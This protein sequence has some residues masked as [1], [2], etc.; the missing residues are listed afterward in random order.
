MNNL[1]GVLHGVQWLKF[2][3]LPE[4][5]SSRLRDGSNTRQ[6]DHGAA[7]SHNS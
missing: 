7:K 1:H 4:F 3:C 2:H 6:G 5:A